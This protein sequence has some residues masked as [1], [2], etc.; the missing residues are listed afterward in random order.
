MRIE[1]EGLGVDRDGGAGRV[2]LGQVA[3]VEADGHQGPRTR[4]FGGVLNRLDV[5]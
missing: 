1:P 4:R 5:A 3:A 2:I